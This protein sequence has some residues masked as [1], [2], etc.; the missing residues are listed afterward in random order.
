MNKEQQHT[1]EV[2]YPSM[3][4]KTEFQSCRMSFDGWPLIGSVPCWS[5]QQV[6]VD[7]KL[8]IWHLKMWSA[9]MILI[10]CVEPRL[11]C[12]GDFNYFLI[13]ISL[14]YLYFMIDF[15]FRLML[16][17]WMKCVG[18]FLFGRVNY[19]SCKGDI[20]G[21]EL[22]LECNVMSGIKL[23]QNSEHLQ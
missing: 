11:L 7:S 23:F 3:S 18:L 8:I 19:E 2:L 6:D 5:R 14:L 4:T 13:F 16:M 20:A 22:V 15:D 1:T 12:G 17:I 10:N 21:C 9:I